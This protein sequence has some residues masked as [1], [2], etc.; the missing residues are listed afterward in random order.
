[1][2]FDEVKAS[3]IQLVYGVLTERVLIW[4]VNRNMLN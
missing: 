3:I 4:E 2:P 1:M